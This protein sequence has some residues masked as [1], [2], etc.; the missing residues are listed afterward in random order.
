MKSGSGNEEK[1]RNPRHN[2]IF[3]ERYLLWEC[4]KKGM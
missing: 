3:G 1:T 4:V 2:Y